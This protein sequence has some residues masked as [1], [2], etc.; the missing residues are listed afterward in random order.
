MRWRD[1]LKQMK[2]RGFTY[3]SQMR[4]QGKRGF[5]IGLKL[6]PYVDEI[7]TDDEA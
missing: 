7:E 4:K 3:N 6:K 5:F 2:Q 1:V